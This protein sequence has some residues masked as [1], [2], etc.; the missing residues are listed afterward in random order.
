MPR[1]EPQSLRYEDLF[2]DVKR[3]RIKIPQ[4]Q[5]DFVWSKEQ[6]ADL[7]DSIIKGFPIGTFIFWRTNEELRHV[8]DIGNVTLPPTPSGELTSYILDGQQRIASLYSVHEGLQLSRG[9]QTIDYKDISIDLDRDLDPDDDDPLVTPTPR[10]NGNSISVHDLLNS[11]T[12][13]LVQRYGADLIDK[14]EEYSDRLKVYAFPTVVIS[15]YPID[16]ACEIFTRINTEG[17]ALTLFEIMVAKTYDEE[18][19]FDLAKEYE[20]LIDSDDTSNAL[21]DAG[22]ETISPA[23]ILQCIAAGICQKVGRK[24]ILK[25]DKSEFI[26]RWQLVK[27]GI[28]AAVDYFRRYLG[29]P[30]SRLLPYENLL[31]PFAYFFIRKNGSQPGSDQDKWLRQYF[32]WASLSQRFGHSTNSRI[33]ED[34]NRIDKILANTQPSYEGETVSLS[35]EDLKDVEFR[36]GDAFCKAILCLY[37]YF[38]PRCF[39][40]NSKVIIDNSWLLRI[41]SKNYH[42]F[43]PRGYLDEAAISDWYANNILNITFVDDNLNKSIIR[44]RPPSDYMKEFAEVNCEIDGTM[45]THLIDDLDAYG[46]WNDDYETF[47]KRRGERVLEELDERLGE[48]GN[49]RMEAPEREAG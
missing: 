22:F 41:N 30:V 38:E 27:H 6:T 42:H 25:L 40:S 11:R 45:K 1:I 3:G 26:E 5:R 49:V 47:I 21:R 31:I 12:S 15:D 9:R 33:E 14:L 24:D 44:A 2:N 13:A 10:S 7:I 8:R 16:I 32:W 48:A 35:L 4:F 34:L 28:F 20:L 39:K 29:I 36:T 43:F 23:T 18:Q 19:E 17:T 46:I 37:A